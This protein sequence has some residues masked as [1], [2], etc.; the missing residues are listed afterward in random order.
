MAAYRSPRI[1]QVFVI[2]MAVA[3]AA[4]CSG[5][6]GGHKAKPESVSFT[7]SGTINGTV[8][9][10][11][12]LTLSGDA[13]GTLTSDSGGYYT[14]TGLTNGSYT[15]TPSLAGHVFT[16]ASLV[17]RIDNA[18]AGAI[19]FTSSA[20]AGD[21][22]RI[23][24]SASVKGGGTLGGVIITLSGA[25]SGTVATDTSGNFV[26]SGLANGD[27]ILTP[28]LSGYVFSP[29][30]AAL[31]LSS[32]D[33]ADVTF[34][35]TA[36]TSPVYTISGTV[37][38]SGSGIQGVTMTLTGTNTATAIT[39]AGGRYT[40]SNLVNGSYTITPGKSGYTFSPAESTKTVNGADATGVN[41]TATASTGATYSISGKVS[42]DVSAGVTVGLS[43]TVSGIT[44]TDSGGN[45]AFNYLANG[46]YTVTPSKA[47]YTFSPT[48]RA[49]TVNSA[50]AASINFTSTSASAPT[51]KYSVSGSVTYPAAGIGFR[52]VTMSLSGPVSG[53]ATTDNSGNY[54]FANLPSGSYSITPAK[55]GYTFTPSSSPVNITASN[56]SGVGFTAT[57]PGYT[58]SGYVGKADGG[59]GVQGAVVQ[60]N[61]NPVVSASTD[62]SGHY[63]IPDIPGGTYT[64]TPGL[65]GAS[66]VFYPANTSISVNSN[67]FQDFSA[68]Y[69]YNISGTISY[70]GSS[71]GW[72]YIGLYY[73][74]GYNRVGRGT[75]ISSPGTY[76]IR[77]VPPGTYWLGAMIDTKGLGTKNAVNPSGHLTPVVV[78]NGDLT[79]QDITISDNAPE[80]PS[81]PTNLQAYPGEGSVSIMWSGTYNSR[82]A[83]TA[84]DYRIYWGTDVN[85]TSGTPITIPANGQFVYFH[86]VP[87]GTYYYKMSALTGGS[88]S[89]TTAVVG[90]VTVAAGAGPNTVSGTVTIPV[91]ATGPLYVGI[92]DDSAVPMKSYGTRIANPLSTQPFSISGVPNGTYTVSAI[93]DMDNDGLVP[94]PGDLYYGVNDIG[95]IGTITVNNADVTGITIPLSASNT[96]V[97]VR[98]AHSSNGTINRYRVVFDIRPLRKLPV[99]VSL[100]AGPNVPVPVDMQREQWPGQ[101]ECSFSIGS[102]RPNPGD[103]YT[104][105]ITYSDGTSENLSANVTGVL[106]SFVQNMAVTTSIPYSTTVPLFTWTAPSSPPA[107]FMYFIEVQEV[108]GGYIWRYPNYSSM[109]MPSSQTSVVY[110]VD[111]SASQP[112][113]TPGT[114][115]NWMIT[116][117]DMVNR[118]KATYFTTYTP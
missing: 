82:Y 115:Y 14:F 109:G 60:L 50:S 29:A 118:N 76:T 79:N 91:T 32:A 42:G 8:L 62:P 37:T 1:V 63:S 66:A 104:F 40:F 103:T 87:D 43:G 92:W 107:S 41:F 53:T 94:V 21:T 19:N 101:Y 16:P 22:Y 35:A 105:A 47:G 80:T 57:G 9:Q 5:G 49:V 74:G 71:T 93:V 77:G 85:A 112:S 102:T 84:T 106:D 18:D 26:F 4:G 113:L 24:G 46:S 114:Q 2:L 12:T 96:Q 83:E 11:V 72:V 23:S 45:F 59:G 65:S 58:V 3:V 98:T 99:K 70:S 86:T 31:S 117:E 25:N 30:S 39:D 100:T 95:S 75:C 7:I 27:Y 108:N 54:S 6:G 44:T 13:T 36:S 78:S 88:E 38:V 55:A 20:L 64:L 34:S 90:P 81:T 68:N 56:I 33:I 97:R 73:P 48:S 10:G 51:P 69:G 52:G 111:S 110:D 116:V 17:V 28:S 67:K 15:V 89:T 61:T